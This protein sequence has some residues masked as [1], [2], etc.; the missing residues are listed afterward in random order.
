MV[1]TNGSIQILHTI[2]YISKQNYTEHK[3]FALTNTLP[4]EYNS[5]NKSV[6]SVPKDGCLKF[7]SSHAKCYIEQNK[8]MDKLLPHGIHRYVREDY[9]HLGCDTSLV[10]HHQCFSVT[11][12]LHLQGT[13]VFVYPEDRGSRLF[14]NMIFTRPNGVT[15]QKPVIFVTGTRTPNLTW[16]NFIPKTV[17]QDA[18]DRVHLGQCNQWRKHNHQ[19]L[20]HYRSCC[21]GKMLPSR[22]CSTSW[23]G[24]ARHMM[25]F[26][27]HMKGSFSNMAYQRRS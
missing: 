4:E 18:Y 12:C 20:A 14:W 13:K 16:Q 24:C 3:I 22:I 5:F 10:D 21:V 7:C 15:S 25:T 2:L 1:F 27:R 8:T 11:C 26:S 17:S 6:T 23:Q 19:W 9:G